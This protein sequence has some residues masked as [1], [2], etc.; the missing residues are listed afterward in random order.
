MGSG[1]TVQV[2]APMRAPEAQMRNTG[3]ETGVRTTQTAL[4]VVESKSGRSCNHSA[5]R[6]KR[7]ARWG[8][9]AG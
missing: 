5:A 7:P 9:P 8:M 2:A 4:Y 1:A 3:D 6:P